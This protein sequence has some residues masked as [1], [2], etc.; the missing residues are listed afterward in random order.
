MHPRAEAQMPARLALDV[1]G[2][3]IGKLALVA[4]AG[5]IG[6]ADEITRL[7]HLPVQLDIAGEAT[8]EALGRGVEAQRLLHRI[9][10]ARGLRHQTA[11]RVGEVRHVE[12]KHGEEARQRLDAGHDER[13]CG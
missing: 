10:H 7:H 2:I 5:A 3:G 8:P 13:H 1:I 11:A 12:G 6:E 9:R 4:V